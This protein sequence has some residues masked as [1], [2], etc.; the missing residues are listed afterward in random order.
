MARNG[1]SCGHLDERRLVTLLQATAAPRRGPRAGR[2]GYSAQPSQ[3]RTRM[4]SQ[5]GIDR[6]LART[7]DAKTTV[8]QLGTSLLRWCSRCGMGDATYQNDRP[9]E[10]SFR[11]GGHPGPERA[12]TW[13]WNDP[14]EYVRVKSRRSSRAGAM[15]ANSFQATVDLQD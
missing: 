13:S 10:K 8:G 15:T 3:T 11:S 12:P 9:R 14:D 5:G 7:T 2:S 1:R 4:S 6:S